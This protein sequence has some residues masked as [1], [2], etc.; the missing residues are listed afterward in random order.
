MAFQ[1]GVTLE[2]LEKV[3]P[4]PQDPLA[5]ARAILFRAARHLDG[6]MV[7]RMIRR[8]AG[9]TDQDDT[10]CTVVGIAAR[11]LSDSDPIQVERAQT[12]VSR[13]WAHQPAAARCDHDVRALVSYGESAWVVATLGESWS[14]SNLCEALRQTAML[15]RGDLVSRWLP[16][17][18]QQAVHEAS[19][20]TAPGPAHQAL[21]RILHFAAH[22]SA[23][24]A[25]FGQL[26]ESLR[27]WCGAGDVELAFEVA[28]TIGEMS[29][30]ETL[31]PHVRPAEVLRMAIDH[32]ARRPTL[33]WI[34][35]QSPKPTRDNYLNDPA[36]GDS[37]DLPMAL[38]RQRVDRREE[39][40]A[41]H[42]PSI[43]PRRPRPRP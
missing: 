6:D 3:H 27:P 29:R 18:V 41:A 20:P 34:L 7:E 12:L 26:W 39:A 43:V 28:S 11:H 36:H 5:L 21:R 42:G 30:M 32:H 2:Q 19:P 24:P 14:F 16:A 25:L 9:W 13:W 23:D 38:A 1:P 33:D 37:S 31:W 10:L 15:G 8:G 22:G 4:H 40:G 17:L 35:A